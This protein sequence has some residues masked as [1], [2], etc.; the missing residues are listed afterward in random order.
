FDAKKN[1]LTLV[2]GATLRFGGKIEGYEAYSREAATAF[3]FAALAEGEEPDPMAMQEAMGKMTIHKFE[4]TLDDD[5]LIDRAINAAATMQGQDPAQMK[6]QINMGLGMA[7][8][9][10]GQVPG[11][12]VALLTDTTSA[13]GKLIS[14]GG[15]LTIKMEPSTPLNIGAAMANPDPANFTKSSLGYSATHK[16]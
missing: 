11:L 16:K 3:D 4:F 6:A 10:A 1:Y 8:M 13:L 5:S 15:S 12:D 2:D 9:M 14:D 7:P